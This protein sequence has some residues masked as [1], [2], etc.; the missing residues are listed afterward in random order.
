[1]QLNDYEKLQQCHFYQYLAPF[2]LITGGSS[3]EDLF[4][5]D[6]TNCIFPEQFERADR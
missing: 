3:M 2:L 5:N 6:F 4:F 1:M